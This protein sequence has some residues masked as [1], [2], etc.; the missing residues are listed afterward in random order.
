MEIELWRCN[1]SAPCSARGCKGR[2]DTLVLHLD[3]QGGVISRVALCDEHVKKTIIN[4]G[5]L[6][7]HDRRP[8]FPE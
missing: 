5:D 8:R 7:V 1:Y 6:K 3:E 4:W 2:A